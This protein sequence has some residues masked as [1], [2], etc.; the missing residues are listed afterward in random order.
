MTDLDQHLPAIAAGDTGAFA[1][2]MAGSEAALRMSLRGFATVVDVEAVVQEALLRVWQVAP[3]FA[4]D[5]RPNGLLR[6]AVRIARNLAV[7]EARRARA[8]PLPDGGDE[9]LMAPAL[10][11]DPLLRK[12]IEDCRDKL[13]DK[14]ASALA[15]RLASAGQAPD[16]ELARGLAMRLNTFLQNVTRARRLLADCLKLRGVDLE[17]EL[18]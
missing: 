5:G 15:A 7:S 10:D 17:L 4:P 1:R 9:A 13:P 3:R 16:E 14:P 18:R 6:L 2:W 12:V 8:A 11:P